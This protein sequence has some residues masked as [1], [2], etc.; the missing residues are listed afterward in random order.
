[1]SFHLKTLGKRLGNKGILF[2]SR[3]HLQFSVFVCSFIPRVPG[4]GGTVGFGMVGWIGWWDSGF[5]GFGMDRM[6]GFEMFGIWGGFPHWRAGGW[7]DLGYLG[8]GMMGF[9]MSGIWDAFPP[10]RAAAWPPG[11]ADPPP[12][13]T[14]SPE[15]SPGKTGSRESGTTSRSG[16]RAGAAGT[17]QGCR[18]G[19]SSKK[20]GNG[21]GK[22]W[23]QMLLPRGA[24]WVSQREKAAQGILEPLGFSLETTLNPSTSNPNTSHHPRLLQRHSREPGAASA[25]LGIPPQ[26]LPPRNSFPIPLWH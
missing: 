26:P 15:P 7:W 12:D 14:P 9:G 5:L 20:P 8:S 1:M 11:C 22:C 16:D 6:V 3:C 23:I 10:W 18:R 24:V 2:A 21:N 25:P 19:G 13:A 17:T 4:G